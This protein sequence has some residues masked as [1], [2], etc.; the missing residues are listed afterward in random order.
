MWVLGISRH[1]NGA[2]CLIHDGN[3]IFYLEEDRLSKI[4]YDGFCQLVFNKVLDYT[5]KLDYVALAGYDPVD[6]NFEFL[7]FNVYFLLLVKL[8]L[9]HSPDQIIDLSQ[10]HHLCH[11]SCGFYNSGFD[12]AVVVVI[13]GAGSIY[14]LEDDC[15]GRETSS[16]IE[17]S[18]PAKF[19]ARFKNIVT[20]SAS[21]K[22]A[23][24]VP[25]SCELNISSNL[26]IGKA[27]Q[28]V[29]VHQGFDIYE[30]GK[31][32]GWASYGQDDTN[33]PETYIDNIAN[34]QLFNHDRTLNVEQHPYISS[35]D[36]QIQANLSKNIQEHTQQQAL[37]L[38]KKAISVTG[39]KNVILTGGYAL[40][41]TANYYIRKNLPTDINLYVEPISHDGGTSIG[42]AKLVYHNESKD[43][44]IHP[45][46]TLFL[47]PTNSLA[48]EL[49]DNE[50][51]TTV[52]PADIVQLLLDKNIVAMYQG[53]S[54]AGPRALGNRSLLFDPRVPNGKDIVNE[55]KRREVFR[56]FAASILEE[57]AN[58]WFDLSGMPNSPFMMY[59]VDTKK[60]TE[61][62]AVVHVD[63][64]CRIQTVNAT[65]VPMFY[66]LIAEFYKQ[67][68]VPMLFNT[69]FNLA[70]DPL[71]ET[72][73]DAIDTLRRSNIE[74][75]Y[76]PETK[77]LVTVTNK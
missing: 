40:N 11:A 50:T 55:I 18:Y 41:C 44:K 1:H 29:S 8:R 5:D 15:I 62:P 27:Y 7:E 3:V 6:Y 67:T 10:N 51:A 34:M 33:I 9:I 37:E 25:P 60:S 46:D 70:G 57:H 43:N 12:S 64:S 66:E 38:I 58:E 35:D 39:N 65:Q 20:T 74:Y 23:Y 48:F 36:F 73:K 28:T 26:D 72:V 68:G 59:A 30:C 54:E 45:L 47:G 13:D 17:F 52:A 61:I 2:I 42:A 53:R 19:N 77:T 24:E 4:K 63:N 75:L 16:I 22:L 71:V 31:T 49:K 32:M 14:A 21:R 56:P 69:S 76:L